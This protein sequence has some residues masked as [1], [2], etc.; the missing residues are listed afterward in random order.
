MQRQLNETSSTQIDLRR[1]NA[2]PSVPLAGTTRNLPRHHFE[3]TKS[4]FTTL[5]LQ[6]ESPQTLVNELK[7]DP[8]AFRK[9]MQT[10]QGFDQQVS[11]RRLPE[12]RS[13][14]VTNGF[15]TFRASQVSLD[16]K[17]QYNTIIREH[18]RQR[19]ESNKG[20]FVAY[21]PNDREKFKAGIKAELTKTSVGFQSQYGSLISPNERPVLSKKLSP[22]RQC[23]E[24]NYMKAIEGHKFRFSSIQLNEPSRPNFRLTESFI[25]IDETEDKEE[26]KKITRQ[27]NSV[28]DPK[29]ALVQVQAPPKKKE[30][31]PRP[32]PTQRIFILERTNP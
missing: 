3:S 7:K 24:P 2:L 32:K 31:K 13:G 26:I 14:S 28:S 18:N 16:S 27:I 10:I 1:P 29:A 30:E 21:D 12:M 19:V 6:K 9:L 5:S 15:A 11:P 8:T 4:S 20:G 22:L 25:Q 17:K 23:H